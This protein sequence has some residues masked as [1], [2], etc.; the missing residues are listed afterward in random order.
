MPPGADAVAQDRAHVVDGA[1]QDDDLREVAVGAGVAGVAH[2]VRDP[3]ADLFLAYQ[4][5]QVV[6]EGGRGAFRA[7]GIDG[8][9]LRRA[10]GPADG[11]CVGCEHLPQ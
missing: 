8:V 7:G 4:P 6:L 11:P 2:Q 3:V 5:G 9:V 1:G 10:C